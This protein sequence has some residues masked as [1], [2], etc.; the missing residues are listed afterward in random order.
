MYVYVFDPEV[1]FTVC[2]KEYW[3]AHHYFD[4]RYSAEIIDKMES[5]DFEELSENTFDYR[6]AIGTTWD[7]KPLNMEKIT[8]AHAILV[9]EGFERVYL[10]NRQSAR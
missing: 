4:D 2:T 1:G 3:D 9:N 8:E 5:L 10:N 7:D 6:N